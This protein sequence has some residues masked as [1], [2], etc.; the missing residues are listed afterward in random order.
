MRR[1]RPAPQTPSISRCITSSADRA[2]LR[3]PRRTRRAYRLPRPATGSF[4][5]TRQ[6][7]SSIGTPMASARRAPILIA[8]FSTRCRSARDRFHSELIAFAAARLFEAAL[9]HIACWRALGYPICPAVKARSDVTGRYGHDD[10]RCRRDR[11]PVQDARCDPQGPHQRRGG[12]P[13]RQIRPQCHRRPYRKPVAQARD[14]FLGTAAL[15]DRGG[16]PDLARAPR[17]VGFRGGGRSS[18]LQRRGRL[19]AGLQGHQRARRPEE[20]AGAEGARAA[21]RDLDLDRCL[22]VWFRATWSMSPP[23]RSCRPICC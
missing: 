7:T 12:S 19:L 1:S 4:C 15:D 3:S 8:Q 18:D 22:R 17:L 11:R 21:R 9:R 14:L 5:S 13:H 10:T 6:P 16:G 20:G 2:T 23:A